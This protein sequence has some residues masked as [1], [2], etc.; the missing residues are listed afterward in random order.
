MGNV[1]VVRAT[2]RRSTSSSDRRKEPYY[3]PGDSDLYSVS[4]DGGEPKVIASIDGGIGDYAIAPDGKR[5]A[6]VG[7]L[8]GTPERSY[9]QTGPVGDRCA[10]RHAA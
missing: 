8:H 3:L 5:I 9:C 1:S 10:R 4:N 2:A 6:F 7:T